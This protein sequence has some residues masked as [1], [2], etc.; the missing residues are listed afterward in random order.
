MEIKEVPLPD[1]I[2]VTLDR[3]E[4]QA[5]PVSIFV[6][7]S[8]ARNDYNERSD[9]EVGVL[10]NRDKKWGRSQLATLHNV[11]GLNIY[12]FVLEDF[13]Q[14]KLDTPFPK[15]VYLR[16]L[17]AGATTVRGQK[18]I[19]EMELPEV[20]L[21][22]L[23]ELATFQTA[24]ALGAVLS[25]RQKDLVT[26]SIEFTKSALFGA[27]A[28]V[29]LELGSFPLGYNDIYEEASKLD[30]LDEDAKAI[31]RHA[32]EVRN[33]QPIDPTLLYKNITFLNQIVYSR[34]KGQL[35]SGNKVVLSGHPV[36]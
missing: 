12:P 28:L 27:R 19:E 24:Y 5:N 32:M 1:E 20:R 14:Y 8:R 16:E 23:I 26:A 2:A 25:V 11:P 10:F 7:G 33:G 31:L 30:F 36:S 4:Q 3:I 35:V 18:I 13:Q 29:A 34:V 15:A 21:S 17:L 9:F 6:Y 22:D